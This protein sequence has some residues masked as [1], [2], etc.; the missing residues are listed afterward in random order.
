MNYEKRKDGDEQPTP[1]FF[2]KRLLPGSPKQ[3][4][5][6]SADETQAQQVEAV[7]VL[8][9]YH[10][11]AIDYLRLVDSITDVLK[12]RPVLV[13]QARGIF[14]GGKP[15]GF[16]LMEGQKCR[17]ESLHTPRTDNGMGDRT[18]GGKHRAPVFVGE[19]ANPRS[20]NDQEADNGHGGGT[21]GL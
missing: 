12:R 20:R 19:H 1:P 14:P 11:I 21:Y 16:W 18:A 8:H 13:R 2:L 17:V 7:Q 10:G 15:S 3:I 6:N 5:E 9:K 4:S